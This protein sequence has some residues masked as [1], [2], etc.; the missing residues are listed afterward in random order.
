M[1]LFLIRHA[2]AVDR[3]AGISDEHRALTERG[4]RRFAR[5]VRGLRKL[6]LR[7]DALVHSP[8]L[9]AMETAELCVPLLDGA[10]R[11][12][13]RLARAPDESLLSELTGERVALVGHE[14]HMAQLLMLACVGWRLIGEG[15]DEAP[16]AFEKGGVAW[17]RGEARVG[18]MQ[19][20]AFLGPDVLRALAE[21]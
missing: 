11:V 12:S 19:L 4:R 7:F 21:D 9:R 16:F 1:D 20:I 15:E 5:S 3:V 10:T 14:P 13:A 6:G 8:L 2:E 18:G 17:L